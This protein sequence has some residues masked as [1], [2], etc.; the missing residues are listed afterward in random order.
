MGEQQLTGPE[1]AAILLLT[2]GEEVAPLVLQHLSEQE[3]QRLSNYISYLQDVEAPVVEQVLS[4]FDELVHGANSLIAGG[5]E[6]V[7]KLLLKVLDPK[8]ADA[9]LNN[10]SMPTM[11]TGL[12]ALKWLDAKT[13]ARFLQNEHP[14]TIAVILAHLE[15]P[16]AGSVLGFLPPALQAD[17]VLRIAKLE[18]VPPG[19]IQELDKVLRHEL[20]AAGALESRQVGGVAAVAEILN[21]VD[22]ASEREILNRIEETNASLAEE[23][24]Q[25]MFVFEDLLYVDD[26]GIQTILKEV[27]NEDLVLALKTASEPLRDKIFRNMSQRAAQMLREELEVMGPV[28]VSDVE[29]AQQKI[30]QVAKRLESEGKIVLGGKGENA[31]V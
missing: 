1:K 24:R 18:R 13:I 5:K 29:K 15:P 16:Q 26:R 22:Q 28:R 27:A 7:R 11:E 2:L 31:F 20:K 21:N 23:I 12:E 3:I 14:Q 25:L 10:L 19:V 6:Y 30:T 17:V 9:I 4:E 8:K